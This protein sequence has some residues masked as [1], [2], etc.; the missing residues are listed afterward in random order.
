MRRLL[1]KQ[2]GCCY[3][4]NDPISTTKAPDHPQR[5]TLDHRMPRCAGGGNDRANLV[6]ACRT[7]NG[8]KGDMPA[9]IFIN[10]HFEGYER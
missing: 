8:L 7:C 2:G 4:C 5:A 1:H 3:Y 6:A 9:S 10:L